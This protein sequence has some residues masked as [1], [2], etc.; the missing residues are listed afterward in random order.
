MIPT[1]CC[2]S[3]RIFEF[4]LMPPLLH[5]LEVDK[6]QDPAAG[7][8]DESGNQF[9]H[10]GQNWGMIGIFSCPNSCEFSREEVAIVQDSGDGA[11]RMRDAGP[12]VVEVQMDDEDEDE[13][14]T[15]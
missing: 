14:E 2:G 9:A 7:E 11:V 3:E 12:M 1:C 13:D 5:V 6:V 15:V 10:G 4:Q 8:T